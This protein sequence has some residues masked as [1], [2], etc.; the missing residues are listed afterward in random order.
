MK[1]SE[2]KQLEFDFGEEKPKAKESISYANLKATK[3]YNAFNSYY[4]ITYVNTSS[5]STSGTTYVNYWG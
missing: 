3:Y 1:Q 4:T 2:S 5:T